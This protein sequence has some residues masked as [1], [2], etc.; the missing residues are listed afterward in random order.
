MVCILLSLTAMLAFL[1]VPKLFLL[2]RVKFHPADKTQPTKTANMVNA[3]LETNNRLGRGH[4]MSAVNTKS[5]VR[6]PSEMGEKPKGYGGAWS[7]IRGALVPSLND[8]S[9]RASITSG[10]GVGSGGTG[11]ASGPSSSVV[12]TSLPMSPG[13]VSVT[14]GDTSV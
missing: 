2:Y 13:G 4:G 7:F 5:I 11:G 1:F 12:I 3:M 8:S 6:R 10:T 9:G 14:P